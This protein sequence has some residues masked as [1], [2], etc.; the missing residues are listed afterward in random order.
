ML[1]TGKRKRLRRYAAPFFFI[2]KVHFG[3]SF[4]YIDIEDFLSVRKIPLKEKNYLLDEE[5]TFS[6]HV[7]GRPEDMA[8][9]ST[10]S[11]I[12][13]FVLQDRDLQDK[14]CTFIFFWSI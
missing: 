4:A 6:D 1:V 7:E 13:S 11:Q 12:R 2:W 3:S 9:Q 14:V 10:L 5:G 8:V